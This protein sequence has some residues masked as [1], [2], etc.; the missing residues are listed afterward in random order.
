MKIGHDYEIPKVLVYGV[1]FKDIYQVEIGLGYGN[2]V[3][4]IPAQSADEARA[5][6]RRYDGIEHYVYSVKGL[7]NDWPGKDQMPALTRRAR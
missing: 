1:E 7:Y 5:I 6:G 2:R 3:V 4:E